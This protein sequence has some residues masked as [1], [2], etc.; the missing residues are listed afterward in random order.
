MSRSRGTSSLRVHPLVFIIL[1]VLCVLGAALLLSRV[2]NLSKLLNPSSTTSIRL[3]VRLVNPRTDGHWPVGAPIPIAAAAI[4]GQPIQSMELWVD[5]ALSQ[6]MDGGQA[7]ATWN[8]TVPSLG[9]HTLL[10]RVQDVQ[11]HVASSNEIRVIGIH[12]DLGGMY[13]VHKSK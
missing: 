11:G 6:R 8:W 4:A 1:A 12:Q 2:L 13:A 3:T 5:G 9:Q 10:V 7:S